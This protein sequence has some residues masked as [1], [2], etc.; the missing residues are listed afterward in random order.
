MEWY[1][2]TP[3]GEQY[4]PVSKERIDQWVAE[5]RVTPDSWV[6]QQGWSDWRSAR[7]VFPQLGARIPPGNPYGAP[8][9]AGAYGRHMVPDRGAAVLTLGILG[10]LV[11]APLAIVAW[12]MG[13]NDL[14]KMRRGEMNNA[15]YGTTQAGMILGIVGTILLAI[16]VLFFIILAAS[17]AGRF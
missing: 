5:G 15:G 10:I 2:R 14:A 8:H 1:V 7:D 12:V 13:A 3:D 9:A 16:A 11:C 17:G 6:F 4:G